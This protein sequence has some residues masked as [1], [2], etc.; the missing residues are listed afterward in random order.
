MSSEHSIS[1]WV[2]SLKAGEIEAVQRL[3]KRYRER[4]VVL[5][6]R[7]LNGAPIRVADEDDIAQS[8]FLSL[9]RGAAEGRF[10]DVKDRDDLWWLLLSLTKRKAVDL[11]RR[12]SAQKRGA[13]RVQSEQVAVGLSS[14]HPG[15]QLDQL[16]GEDPTPDLLVMMEEQHRRLLGLLRDD[17]LR[18]IAV[19][20]IEGYTVAEI[21]KSLQV[22]TRSIE[23][24]LSLI[25]DVWTR[26]LLRAE[27]RAELT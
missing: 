19:A 26:E 4:L 15:I 25:R 2:A 18:R 12:E 23:R 5:A 22:S 13:G 11:I 17:H 21:A 7:R 6:R 1:H 10:E 24:K 9:C 14:H 3:W 16:I 8:V 20:R 27:E